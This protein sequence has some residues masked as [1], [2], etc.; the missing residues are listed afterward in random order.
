MQDKRTTLAKFP[1]RDKS[2]RKKLK[3]PKENRLT[4]Y[5]RRIKA[6][7]K[8]DGRYNGWWIYQFCMGEFSLNMN[9]NKPKKRR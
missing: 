1:S 2:G 6:I 9:K 7:K 8:L 5:D 3:E 4:T